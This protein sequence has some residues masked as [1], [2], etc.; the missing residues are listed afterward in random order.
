MINEFLSKISKYLLFT[1]E[2]KQ[3]FHKYDALKSHEGWSVHQ[4]FLIE[5]M[6]QISSCMLSGQFTK[7]NKEEKDVQQRAFYM[8]KEI[9]EFLLDPLKNA[10]RYAALQKVANKGQGRSSK[11]IKEPGTQ[12]GK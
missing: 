5:I 12:G 11:N 6:N 8:T 4:G 3:N 1:D 10:E 9:I 2:G 7:Q